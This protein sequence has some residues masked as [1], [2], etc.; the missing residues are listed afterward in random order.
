MSYPSLALCIPAY[1]AAAYLPRLLESAKAQTKNFDEIWVY[2]DCS[3]DDTAIVAAQYGAQVIRGDVN[4]GCSFGKNRLAQQTQC[5]WIHFHDADD[6]LYP[7]FVQQAYKWMSLPSPPDV[8]LFAYDW[9]DN[10]TK[11]I[12][13][14]KQFDD[15]ALKIDAIEYTIKTQINPFCGLYQRSSLLEAGGYDTDPNVLYNEDVAFHCR[16]AIQGLSFR[17]DPNVTVINYCRSG[18][19]SVANQLKCIQAQ[20]AVMNKVATAVGERYGRVIASRLW[21]IAAL[22]AAHLDWETC[23]RSVTLATQLHPRPSE[24]LNGL[25]KHLCR[26]NPYLAMRWRESLIRQF[27]PYLRQNIVVKGT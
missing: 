7:H 1:N 26:I 17:A 22:S 3:T 10:E 24:E 23:D 18:S 27:R 11:Q 9:L 16:L 19:M 20:Y 13:N 14:Q 25:F 5:N 4:R 15:Q 21:G 2:D 12:L 8:V 6:A